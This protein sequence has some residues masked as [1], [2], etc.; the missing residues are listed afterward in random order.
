MA[1]GVDLYVL[2]IT[3]DSFL[4][5]H[6]G[7]FFAPEMIYTEIRNQTKWFG[8]LEKNAHSLSCPESDE[9]IDIIPMSVH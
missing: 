7:L 6:I 2:R 1:Q 4:S 8:N 5:A 9:R 3:W